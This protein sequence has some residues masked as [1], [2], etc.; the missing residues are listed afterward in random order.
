MEC[1]MKIRTLLIITSAA[2]LIVSMTLF[3]IFVS[4]QLSSTGAAIY[5]EMVYNVAS[6][7]A[8]NVDAYIGTLGYQFKTISGNSAITD[9]AGGSYSSGSKQYDA[10]LSLMNAYTSGTDIRYID[11]V[12]GSGADA[13]IVLSS[14]ADT[15]DT[16][17]DMTAYASMTDSTAYINGTVI[18]GKSNEFDIVMKAN[19]GSYTLRVYFN[20]DHLA[21]I[22][23]HSNFPT[24]GRIIVI[25]SM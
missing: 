25:D 18:S 1:N 13:K 20:S 21:N 10:A 5:D 16:A 22:V 3:G 23:T 7:Q 24:N 17:T 9:F 8:S 19:I 4:S 6:S 11:F 12:S 14:N 15:I 2:F